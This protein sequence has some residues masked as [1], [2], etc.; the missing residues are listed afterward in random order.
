LVFADGAA[1]VIAICT[2]QGATAEHVDLDLVG[3]A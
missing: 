2:E 3:L 1:L